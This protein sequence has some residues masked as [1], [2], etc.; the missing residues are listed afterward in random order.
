MEGLGVTPATHVCGGVDT[1]AEAAS[2]RDI[3][4]TAPSSQSQA[5]QRRRVAVVGFGP[6]GLF[7]ALT[8]AEEGYD[9][10]VIE[11]GKE[12]ES[13]GKDIGALVHRR[14]LLEDSNFCFGEGG[15]GTWSDG[16]LTTRIG[17]TSYL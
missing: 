1:V 14:N 13:R 7:A 17:E 5:K 10:T 11:R 12:V 3:V 4:S 16:K 6:A 9:V 8:L 15:A 2:R